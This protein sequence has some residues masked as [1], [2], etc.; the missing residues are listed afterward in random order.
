MAALRGGALIGGA[1]DQQLSA[2][3]LYGE[4]L[5]L[6]FQITDDILDVAGDIAKLGKVTGADVRKGKSTYVTLLGLEE[7]KNQAV[8]CVEQC[9]R[10]ADG[11]PNQ[12]ILAELAEY[13]V[14]RES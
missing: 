6:A 13:V 4:N 14:N 9:K 10:Y 11:L 12:N 3:T 8:K 1:N 5:G 2:I 7:A